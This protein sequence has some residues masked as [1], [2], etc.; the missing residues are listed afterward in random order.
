MDCSVIGIESLC[1]IERCLH[2]DVSLY[3]TLNTGA[4]QCISCE[5]FWIRL[6]GRMNTAS[7]AEPGLRPVVRNHNTLVTISS[8]GWRARP[9]SGHSPRAY[10]A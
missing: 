9:V 6:A 4:C 1:T 2:A 8:Q 7:L 10:L 5:T 3:L